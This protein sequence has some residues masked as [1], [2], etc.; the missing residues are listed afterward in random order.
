MWR[1]LHA[2]LFLCLCEKAGTG[3]IVLADDEAGMVYTDEIDK[4]KALLK[5]NRMEQS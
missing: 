2:L 3:V 5:V 1:V 4:A